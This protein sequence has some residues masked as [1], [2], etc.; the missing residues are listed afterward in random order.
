MIA[1]SAAL[2]HSIPRTERQGAERLQLGRQRAPALTRLKLVADSPRCL[3]L[4]F[5]AAMVRYRRRNG[6]RYEL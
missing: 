4:L 5:Y 1:E 2:P 3:R 6:T